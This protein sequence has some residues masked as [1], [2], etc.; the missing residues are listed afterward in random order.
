MA[1]LMRQGMATWIQ[2]WSACAGPP[3]PTRTPVGGPSLMLPEGVRG[4]VTRLLV[5][6]ALGASRGEARL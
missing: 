3:R 4:D 2:A 1:L 5:T 6:M